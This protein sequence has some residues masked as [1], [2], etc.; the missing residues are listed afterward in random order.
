VFNK[1]IIII[2]I[3]KI[4]HTHN[5]KIGLF[6]KVTKIDISYFMKYCRVIKNLSERIFLKY[7]HSNKNTKKLCLCSK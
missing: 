7:V 2:I 3:K 6:N 4:K 5:F 1:I